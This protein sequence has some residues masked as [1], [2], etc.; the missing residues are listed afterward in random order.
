MDGVKNRK[1][2]RIDKRKREEELEMSPSKCRNMT[3]QSKLR[4][5]EE[6]EEETDA[7]ELR[8]LAWRKVAVARSTRCIV[9]GA[10]CSLADT[11]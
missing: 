8:E 7:T 3:R 9:P 10:N 5:I 11:P 6:V 4:K 2:I 1:T